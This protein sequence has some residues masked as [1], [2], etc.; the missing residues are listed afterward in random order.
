M[1]RLTDRPRWALTALVLGV[2]VGLSACRVTPALPSMEVKALCHRKVHAVKAR[3]SADGRQLELRFGLKGRDAHA[4]GD[5]T[6][7]AAT[8][9]EATA[10]AE[11]AAGLIRIAAL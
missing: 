8:V 4:S 5:L 11:K 1:G 9:E 6:A 3:V 7:V 10:L 2:I